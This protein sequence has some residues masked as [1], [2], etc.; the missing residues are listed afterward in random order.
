MTVSIFLLPFGPARACVGLRRCAGVL[1]RRLFVLLNKIRRF[2]SFRYFLYRY[3][4]HRPSAERQTH[5]ML[6]LPRQYTLKK[7]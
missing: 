1:R 4:L 6:W 5:F 2:G 7:R 3:Q